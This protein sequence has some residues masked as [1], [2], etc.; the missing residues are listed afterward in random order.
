MAKRRKEGAEAEEPLDFQIPKFDE[1]AFI[2]KERRNIKTMFIAFLF[3]LLV[4]AVCFGFWVLLEGSFLRWE[5]V[6]L[7]A[8]VNSI[9]IRYIF[10]K[11]D[12]DLTDF[13]RKGWLT[14][15]VT[16][17][18]TWLLVLIVLVNPPFYDG[19]A[20]HVDLVLLPG[21]QE[22]GG[23]ILFAAYITDNIGVTK[24]GITFTITDPNGT[25]LTPEFSFEKSILRYTYQNPQN[26]LGTFNYTAVVSD[27]NNRK[28]TVS[29]SFSYSTDVLE[30]SAR[31]TDII[32]TDSIIIKADEQISTNNFRVFYRINDG[33]DINV[34]R[35]EP[36][37][38]GKY[39]T[40]AEFKGW[41]AN[42][43]IDVTVFAE[44]RHYFIN[45]PDKFSNTVRDSETHLF[46]TANDPNIGTEDTLVEWNATLAALRQPQPPN[47]LNYITPYP[48]SIGATPGFEISVF[49]VAIVAVV[50]LF[51]RRKN[52]K[53]T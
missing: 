20:P 12:I 41:A 32:S 53:T 43:T 23:T 50:F 7:V 2:K 22:P 37:I 42:S 40:S 29:G 38:K 46:T 44:A 28:T 34:N 35:D 19:E 27:T 48:T 31:T 1:E 17:F 5:L 16:Y 45:V 9:W 49:L 13:G 4:A 52:K 30:V 11:L 3:G 15:F 24:A 18:F 36:T 25:V 6:L 39:E 14:S 10:L 21:M 26:L 8:V 33:S 51:R 47:T